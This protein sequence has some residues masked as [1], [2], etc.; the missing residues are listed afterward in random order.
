MVRFVCGIV[1]YLNLNGS[2][3]N[4]QDSTVSAMC[5][6][7]LHRGP[8]EQGMTVKGPVAL[9]MTRLSI[10]DLASGQQPITNEDKTV[11]IVFNGE[12]YNF[13]KLQSKLR[14][15]GHKLAT[16][17]DTEVIVH[18]YE[19]YGIDCL[20]FLEGMFSFAIWDITKQR[21]FI[22]RDRMGEK[23]LHWGIF[24]GQLIFGSEIKGIL[25]HPSAKRELDTLALRK[26][27]ALEYVPAPDTIF[28][29]IHKLPPAHFM[30]VE[31]GSLNIKHYWRPRI[32]S[33]PI[34]ED[35][36]EE[37]FI[38]L[39]EESVRT[40]LISD[41][42]LG[43]FLSGGID[44]SGITAV[45]ARMA[46]SRLKTFSIGFS[47]TTYD[48][49][50]HAK[51]VADH[52]GTDH[53]VVE[54]SPNMAFSTMEELWNYIDEPLA[55]ASILPTFFLSK[56]TKRSVTV[57]L[58][59]DGGDE[60]FGG[61]PTYQAH[62]YAQIWQ[63]IPAFVR[64]KLINPLIHGLPVS[65]NNLSLDFKA[66]RFISAADAEPLTRHLRWMGAIPLSE[67]H[68]L[69]RP[70]IMDA[71]ICDGATPGSVYSA[72]EDELFSDLNYFQSPSSNTDAAEA[73]MRLDLGSY[74]PE[75]LLVKSDRAS[76]AA[77]LEVR[78]PFLAYPLVEFALSLPTSLKLKNGTTKYLPKKAFASMLPEN[79]LRRPKKGFGIPVAKW[80]NADFRPIVD[81]L[82]DETFL[83][84]QG[85][86]NAQY[87]RELVR[88]HRHGQA[89]RRKEL[90]T[91]L[92]F[93][94]WY[95]AV[96]VPSPSVRS[97]SLALV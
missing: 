76:M 94:R 33:V 50:Q 90:W 31:N 52:I 71:T 21:L 39:L 9:G 23:P 2:P 19:D 29:G 79:I 18:L 46:S 58:S 37:R 54:F 45:A 87:V 53:S 69:L 61:Y 7:I 66:K 25:S 59:G 22:A 96:L 74:L 57:A 10:I 68:K 47:D 65:L 86:F 73:M 40:R 72:G 75:D 95:Q 85:I 8:D 14:A 67:H 84:R 91:L 97:D 11:W 41:V 83:E 49:S 26:Y 60:L 43:I 93:Q 48:E 27:L 36:A 20:Q 63:K 82:L 3:L 42:P 35:E 32:Q 81:E 38:S 30:V 24:D 6:S 5:R 16:N 88:Q 4:P 44:S 55:D 12:I 62:Q 15:A 78:I 34:S 77:S 70:E 13:Q 17:S 28:R 92:M 51:M 89:D 80:I 56:M 64:R 1:G